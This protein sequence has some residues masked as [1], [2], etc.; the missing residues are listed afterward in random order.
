MKKLL[1]TLL[2]LASFALAQGQ[3]VGPVSVTQIEGVTSDGE[4][5]TLDVDTVKGAPVWD[6][7]LNPTGKVVFQEAFMDTGTVGDTPISGAGTR[8][9]W[10]PSK[11]SFRAG[12]VTGTD[13]DAGNIGNYSMAFGEDVE[14]SGSNSTAFGKQTAATGAW[15]TAFGRYGTA[16]GAYSTIFGNSGTASGDMGVAFGFQTRADL[17]SQ[18]SH[19]S[20]RFVSNGDAQYYRV[21]MR[22]TTQAA[23]TK[24]LYLDGYSRSERMVLQANRTVGF[25]GRVVAAVT[26]GADDNKTA[27]YT[28]NGLIQRV[29]NTTTLLWSNVT[30]DYE[31]ADIA[32]ALDVTIAADDTNESLKITVTGKA[33]STIFW[34]AVIEAVEL[35]G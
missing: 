19:A 14:A 8:M 22:D 1:I 17:Y 2:V 4:D 16:S 15:S 13:W 30:A 27:T 3:V 5:V 29:G 20:G 33:A 18:V 12:T 11:Y 7:V 6:G 23:T 28:I 31:H 34:V 25:D 26:S 9:M 21:V 24:E 35:T 10:V 32:A